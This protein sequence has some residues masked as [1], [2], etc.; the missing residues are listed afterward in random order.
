MAYESTRTFQYP[1]PKDGAIADL[2]TGMSEI[3]V[4]DRVS[5]LTS[6]IFDHCRIRKPWPMTVQL[7]AA[8]FDGPAADSVVMQLN[9]YGSYI[10]EYGARRGL[11]TLEEALEELQAA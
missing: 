11:D 5:D 2:R 10:W 4:V 7:R 9:A 3:G 1:K 8:V 6:T